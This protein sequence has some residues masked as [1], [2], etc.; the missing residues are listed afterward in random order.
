M[1]FGISA[2][3]KIQVMVF[4]VV[5]PCSYVVGYQRFGA[6]SSETL[7]SPWKWRQQGPPKHRYTSPSLHSTSTHKTAAWLLVYI[8]K[9]TFACH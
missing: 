4:W 2:A 8:T 5:T 1:R 3:M 6:C 7:V 9:Q